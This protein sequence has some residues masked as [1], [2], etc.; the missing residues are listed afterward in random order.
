MSEKVLFDLDK[1]MARLERQG[2]IAFDDV[3]I[4]AVIIE[5]QQR[6]IRTAIGELCGS[7]ATYLPTAVAIVRRAHQELII[8]QQEREKELLDE[9]ARVRAELARC[10]GD[11]RRSHLGEM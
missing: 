5:D 10:R 6:Q 2:V 11:A 8:A 7:E 9:I 4:L 3:E 1:Y